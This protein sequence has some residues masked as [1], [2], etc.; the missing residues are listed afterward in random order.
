VCIHFYARNKR[1]ERLQGWAG[2]A[3]S[4]WWLTYGL[5]DRDYIPGKGRNFRLFATASRQAP[6]STQPPITWAL[7]TPFPG[8]NLPGHETDYSPTS[9]P[10]L[11]HVFMAMCLITHRLSFQCMI[12]K[13]MGNFTFTFETPE[14]GKI[15][16]SKF[17]VTMFLPIVN[18]WKTF[19]KLRTFS[20][21]CACVNQTDEEQITRIWP[22][23]ESSSKCHV[24]SLSDNS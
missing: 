10:S 12:L 19:S 15:Y 13:H 1:R 11:S 20:R 18:K 8:A 17:V 3:Q 16:V 21:P 6:R 24:Y 4:V 9:I 23:F 7:G 5:N 22:P 2:V 14:T